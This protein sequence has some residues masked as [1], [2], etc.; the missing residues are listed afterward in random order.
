MLRLLWVTGGIL[1][2][3]GGISAPNLPFARGQQPPELTVSI[4]E[5]VTDESIQSGLRLEQQRLW[6]DAIQHYESATRQHPDDASLKQRLLVCRIHH[7]VQRRY[8]DVTFVRSVGEMSLLQALDLYVEL[9]ANMET[10]Y[11]DGIDWQRLVRHGSA[12][13]EVAL[14]EPIFIEKLLPDAKPDAIE[15]FRMAIHKQVL[16]RA[17]TSRHELRAIASQVAELAKRELGLSSTAVVLEFACG[18]LAALDPYSR[19]LTAGQLEETFS[20]I[21]GNFVGLG[22]ELKAAGDRLQV[23]NV[24]AGGPAAEAGLNPG[25]AIVQVDQTKTSEVSPDYAADLLRGPEGSFVG[26]VV[27][28]PANSSRSLWVERRRVEVPCVENVHIVDEEN[29]IGY[30]RLTSFQKTTTRELEKALW[31][32]HRLGMKSLIIDVRGNP[33]GL[34]TAAVE[35]ADRFLSAG[36]IVTTRGRNARENFDY[37]AHRTNTWNVPLAVLIDP[38]SASASEIFAGAIRDQGRGQL[39]GQ[40]S[41]GKGSVQGIFRM[42][43]ADC[44][45]C[46][47]TAKFYSPSGQAISELGVQPHVVVE[48]SYI[49]ARPNAQGE[50]TRDAEDRVLQKAIEVSRGEARLTSLPR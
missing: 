23:V 25:D 9:L 20:S 8:Q 34:L 43:A 3:A 24:I 44:G 28:D 36:R 41:Y 49:A 33:G 40:T 19:F 15:T 26:L 18:S 10:H 27:V 42:Q 21:E 45:L 2:F 46:L 32:L 30:L 4:G 31:D 37:S 5:V 50:I 47:T 17:T 12:S 14:T 39:I 1:F 16:N 11:V 48:P 29:H 13:L 35:V 6:L 38:D 7:D 22:I